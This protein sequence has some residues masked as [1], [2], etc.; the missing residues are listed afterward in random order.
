MLDKLI[1][2][3][4][5]FALA[6]KLSLPGGKTKWFRNAPRQPPYP[7]EVEAEEDMYE[8]VAEAPSEIAAFCAQ[9]VSVIQ[10]RPAPIS[11]SGGSSSTLTSPSQSSVSTPTA[12][13]MSSGS[14]A[15]QNAVSPSKSGGK[16]AQTASSSMV[17]EEGVSVRT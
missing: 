13:S 8:F 16:I 15:S 17:G 7:W 6:S 12:G 10:Q 5:R 4:A 9:P 3:G 2:Y 14:V 11:T 1:S